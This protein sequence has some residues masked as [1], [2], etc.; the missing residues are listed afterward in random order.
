MITNIIDEIVD[1]F[2]VIIFISTEWIAEIFT[3]IYKF[4]KNKKK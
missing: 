1:F 3:D 2:K 4:F